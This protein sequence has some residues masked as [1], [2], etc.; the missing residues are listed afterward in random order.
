MYFQV[1]ACISIVDIC[2]YELLFLEWPK[3]SHLKIL[4]FPLESLC[5]IV[6]HQSGLY[7]IF[8]AKFS[9]ITACSVQRALQTL[10]EPNKNVS[11]AVDVR[12]ELDLRIGKTLCC[13][14][15]YFMSYLITFGF[16]CYLPTNTQEE[17]KCKLKTTLRGLSPRANHTDRA[18]AAGRRS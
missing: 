9:E 4:N 14:Y 2:S 18:A 6:T 11:D 1:H 13:L 8:R 10:A 12:Q 17:W 5:I 3:L 16:E 7:I 15:S